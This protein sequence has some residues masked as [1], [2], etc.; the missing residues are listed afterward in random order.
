MA[1]ACDI[2]EASIEKMVA[3][4]A[5]NDLQNNQHELPASSMALEIVGPRMEQE[6]AVRRNSSVGEVYFELGRDDHFD[7]SW[8]PD[9]PGP[10]LFWIPKGRLTL[11][12]RYP[13]YPI[14]RFRHN[15][16]KIRV[17]PPPRTLAFSFAQAASGG[18]YGQDPSRLTGKRR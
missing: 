2:L 15:A 6:R 11:D 8:I 17:L 7:H 13:A 14:D 16:H 5:S 10:G 12:I 9:G 3:F 1:D 4:D 18:E